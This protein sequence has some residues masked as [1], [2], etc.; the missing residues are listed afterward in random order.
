MADK[1]KMERV[2]AE[3]PC[4]GP[5]HRAGRTML[6]LLLTCGHEVRD[7][8][9]DSAS[10]IGSQRECWICARDAKNRPATRGVYWSGVRS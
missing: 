6:R 3:T 2:E 9:M 4:E 7:E 10:W 1:P 8:S 5:V